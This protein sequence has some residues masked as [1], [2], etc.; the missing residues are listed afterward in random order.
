MGTRSRLLIHRVSKPTIYLWMHWDGY[1]DGVGAWLCEQIKLLLAK[2]TIP[3]IQTMLDA[4]DLGTYSAEDY[5]SFKVKDLIPFIEG[6]TTYKND[7]CDDIMYEYELDF[8]KQTLIGKGPDGGERDVV[9]A[10]SFDQMKAG[11]DFHKM[12]ESVTRVV[13]MFNSLSDA[14]KEEA[15]RLIG[16]L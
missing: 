10:L 14:E 4:L 15:R 12:P 8:S 6:K 16:E 5:Q 11:A 1:F 13:E 7:F 9:R 3:E 2:Y